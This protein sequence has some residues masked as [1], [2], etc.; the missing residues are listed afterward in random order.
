MVR[1]GK[2]SNFEWIV[3][4][5]EQWHRKKLVIDYSIQTISFIG[6]NII[7]GVSGMNYER[8]LLVDRST[9]RTL[10][11]ATEELWHLETKTN[12]DFS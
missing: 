5:P 3:Q 11:Y 6:L 4:L 12:K 2:V 9:K 7:Y 10:S 8:S 1:V